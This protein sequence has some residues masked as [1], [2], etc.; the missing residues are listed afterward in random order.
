MTLA[1]ILCPPIPE[2]WKKEPYVIVKEGEE[3]LA[4]EVKEKLEQSYL[5]RMKTRKKAEAY[6]A[7]RRADTAERIARTKLGKSQE[8]MRANAVKAMVA[9][10]E[11]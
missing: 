8:E 1:D 5:L 7:K 9:I 2:E 4:E 10:G 6:N 3:E 11:G